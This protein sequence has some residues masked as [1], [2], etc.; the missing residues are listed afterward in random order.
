M[1]I[2]APAF[3]LQKAAESSL[4]ICGKRQ[5]ARIVQDR[6]QQ[7]ARGKTQEAR[8]LRILRILQDRPHYLLPPFPFNKQWNVY[9]RHHV[10]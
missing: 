3:S 9:C 10:I 6:T 8:I 4:F 1:H 5:E 7:D 2:Y